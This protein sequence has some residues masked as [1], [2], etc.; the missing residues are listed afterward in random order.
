MEQTKIYCNVQVRNFSIR[1]YRSTNTHFLQASA[2]EVCKEGRGNDTH[3]NP[4][5]ALVFTHFSYGYCRQ[6]LMHQAPAYPKCLWYIASPYSSAIGIAAGTN[7]RSGVSEQSLDASIAKASSTGRAG[8]G[9]QNDEQT[10][11]AETI[12]TQVHDVERY[13]KPFGEH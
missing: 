11:R 9:N 5:L 12:Q 4:P 6:L 7:Q 2:G 1:T 10:R 3:E 13:G 8:S